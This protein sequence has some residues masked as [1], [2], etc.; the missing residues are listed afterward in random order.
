[1]VKKENEKDNGVKN[2]NLNEKHEDHIN[3]LE[4]EKTTKRMENTKSAG[5]D[6]PPAE[7]YQYSGRNLARWVSQI[8]NQAW[9]QERA[10][11]LRQFYY[12]SNS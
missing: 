4:V 6:N 11:R 12:L 10:G 5:S 1:M 3:L 2:L 7:I 8:F 9:R